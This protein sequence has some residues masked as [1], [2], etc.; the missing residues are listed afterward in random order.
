MF[1]KVSAGVNFTMSNSRARL[2]LSQAQPRPK[3]LHF[4]FGLR[5]HDDLIR[6]GAVEAFPRPLAR[7]VNSHFGS[8]V[9][10]AGGGVAVVH[11]APDKKGVPPQGGYGGSPSH[12]PPPGLSLFGLVHHH[13]SPW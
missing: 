4:L 10:Q 11:P 13:R 8:E 9:R 12:A 7:G 3:T 1:S 2:N 5:V 6:P